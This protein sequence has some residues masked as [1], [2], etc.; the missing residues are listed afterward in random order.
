M[1]YYI[2]TCRSLTYAQRAREVLSAAGFRG[3]VIKTPG[4]IAA[5]GCG[6]SV[7]LLRGRLEDALALLGKQGLGPRKIFIEAA[8][9]YREVRP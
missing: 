2:L 8:D 5:S 7:K 6:Y 9:G 3:A 1:P 4:A